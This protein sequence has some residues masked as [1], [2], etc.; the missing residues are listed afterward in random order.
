MG[1]S[2]LNTILAAMD[3]ETQD[4][5]TGRQT[6]D[7]LTAAFS[8]RRV[9]HS[10][11]KGR[12]I[13][14]DKVQATWQE[15]MNKQSGQEQGTVY[16]HIP[17]CQ[18]RCLYCGFF[19]NYSNEEL[20]TAY[21]DRLVKELQ[22]SEGA[23]YFRNRSINAV[24]MGGGTPSTLSS[25]NISRLLGA[26]HTYLPLANDYELT[27]EGRINDLVP[28][29]IETWLSGGVNRFSIG[30]QSFNTQVRRR[31]GR[32]DDEQTVLERLRLLAGYNQAAVIIDLIYGLPGQDQDVWRKD[33]EL[34]AS[35]A[36]DGADLYQLNVFPNSGLQQAIS[37]GLIA[38]AAT[39]V[40]Q[41][42]MFA[43]AA[44]MLPE[45]GFSRISICHWGKNRR[46]RN[47]YN[48]LTKEGYPVVPFGAGA[49]GKVAG[50]SLFLF[51]NTEQYLQSI[52]RGE[53]PIAGMM[54]ALVDSDLH[55]AILGQ[56]EQG[57]IDLAQLATR[58]DETVLDLEPLLAVWEERGLVTRGPR[59]AR[60]T[61]AGQFWYN[62]IGQA[63][64]ECL[65]VLRD[66]H[67][68]LEL[69]PIAAQG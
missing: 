37:T 63:A 28:E 2:K 43:Q 67:H 8:K 40:E 18:H 42:R 5:M 3:L 31:V 22:M 39:T 16:I 12:P 33:L 1:D 21:V 34:M 24:F 65:Q 14:P 54:H 29:K 56:L 50:K 51:R 13:P 7:P 19:Q 47:L 49:G 11:V 35:S 68:A 48:T 15:A 53:K 66:G 9:V 52:D 61:I 64:L 4:W 10:G 23:S 36:I 25:K 32:L 6:A 59:L 27:L 41:A 26:I 44:G 62:N 38:P 30:V 69:Q 55:N 20:E 57:Y 60:L 17:F 58:Y 46:E 45:Y